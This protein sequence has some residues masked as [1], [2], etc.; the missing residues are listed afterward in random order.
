[1]VVEVQ[2]ITLILVEMAALAV[3]EEVHHLQTFHQ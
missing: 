1:V 3:E 2:E